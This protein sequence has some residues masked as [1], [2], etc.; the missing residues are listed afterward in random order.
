MRPDRQI[1]ARSLTRRSGLTPG[2]A[3]GLAALRYPR[4]FAIIDD[5]GSLTFAEVAERTTALARSFRSIGIGEDSIVALMCCNHRGVIEATV[6]CAKVG[7]DIL[8]LDPDAVQSVLADAV[9]R[10]PPDVL[11]YDEDFS[12]E[13]RDLAPTAR[14]I[15][16]WCEPGVRHQGPT[17]DDLTIDAPSGALQPAG[18]RSEVA[19][20]YEPHKLTASRKLS[21]SLITPG[22]IN[23]PS[24]CVGATLSCLRGRSQQ[25]GGS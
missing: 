2:A 10:R 25:G 1:R 13:V 7:A 3:Y 12:D 21:C 14:R 4:E 11:I 17:L 24:H 9:W 20:T 5:R 8:Y 18:R 15:I 19:F 6:A 23:S 22:A 16:A